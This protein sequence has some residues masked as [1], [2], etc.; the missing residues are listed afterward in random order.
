MMT[1]TEYGTSQHLETRVTQGDGVEFYLQE[2]SVP[3]P[4]EHEV[5]VRVEAAPLNPSD[6][7]AMFGLGALKSVEEIQREGRKVVRIKA[8]APPANSASMVGI[9][10]PAGV[11]CAG[12][13][14][15]AGTSAQA[16]ALL[17]RTVTVLGPPAFARF[18]C[19]KAA[20]C[21]AFPEGIEPRE[22][23]SA[24]VNPM[25]ALAM[26][27]TMRLDGH[28][29]IV[30]TAA[31]SN[32]GQMLAKLCIEEDIDLVAIVRK[33]EQRR[34]L[35]ELGVKYVLNSS[36]PDF[37]DRLTDAL[38]ATGAT[39]AFDAIAG[40]GLIDRI[41]RCME[42]AQLRLVEGP[43]TQYGTPVNKQVHV[44]GGLDPDAMVIGPAMARGYGMTWTVGGWLLTNV[45]NRVGPARVAEL[46]QRVA[47]SIRTIFKSSYGRE[48]SL[49]EAVS[50]KA[51]EAF[52]AQTTG[53]KFLIT[54][55]KEV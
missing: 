24:F 42:S 33:E 47:D 19:V 41:L 35:S 27:E 31:A 4:G 39:V 15:A 14:V 12:R 54:P 43:T 23:A 40:G 5:I 6:I 16:Q 34:M 11:E 51:I 29:A 49:E 1:K 18:K 37:E 26:I 22:V 55:H 44:Y 7:A 46:R 2:A 36:Q 28:K 32:L 21:M 3:D 9:G 20:A 48:I 17:G 52:F 50:A 13:V 25:T 38:V 8:S 10:R 30:H 45:L 53:G